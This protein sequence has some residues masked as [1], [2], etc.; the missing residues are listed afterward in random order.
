[1]NQPNDIVWVEDD[2]P[3]STRFEDIYFSKGSGPAEVE[4]VF[5]KPNQIEQRLE[6][7]GPLRI[8]ELG[9]GTGLSFL[10]TWA[11]Q[12][13]IS[14]QARLDFYS[15]EKYPI[16]PEELSRTHEVW[17]DLK[18]PSL[19]F[20]SQ[21]STKPGWNHFTFGQVRC[22][23]YVGDV[24]DFLRELGEQKK[25][26]QVW[27]LDGFAPAKNPQMWSREVLEQVG[28]GSTS[29]ST[30]STYTVVGQVRRDLMKAGFQVEKIKGFENKREMLFGKM[31]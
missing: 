3:Y 6:A 25:T 13:K 29:G 15:V 12:T 8:G 1:M 19:A 5:L 18:A 28:Q 23:V 14:P 27:Y 4:H 30:F 11:L 21:W 26:M 10:M 20:Q 7:G 22:H 2:T 31:P 17:P 16:Q 9:F 24:L